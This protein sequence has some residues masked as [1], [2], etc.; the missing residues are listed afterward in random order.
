MSE[1]NNE[2]LGWSHTKSP[3]QLYDSQVDHTK[4]PPFPGV[5]SILTLNSGD[6]TSTNTDNI[7]VF[8]NAR[9]RNTRE[10]E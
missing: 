1:P 5:P 3:H 7:Y 9:V 10:F 8:G 2:P 4:F 6:T